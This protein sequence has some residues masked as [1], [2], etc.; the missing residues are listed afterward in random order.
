MYCLAAELAEDP[1]EERP[2]LFPGRQRDVLA[3]EGA[4]NNN[5]KKK[6]KRNGNNDNDNNKKKKNKKNN[7][8]NNDNNSATPFKGP[9]VRGP[10]IVSL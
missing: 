4:P 10:L 1:G 8:K 6:K 7:N 3:L 2:V 9:L 5:K